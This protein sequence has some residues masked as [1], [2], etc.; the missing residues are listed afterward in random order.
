LFDYDAMAIL[1]H[2]DTEDRWLV[3]RREGSRPPA[4]L[5]TEELPA[6]V[7]KALRQ[8]TVVEEPNLL[9]GM[10]PGLAGSAGSGMYACLPARGA[11]IGLVVLEH[12]DPQHFSHRDAELLA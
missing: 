2:E 5:R 10:G 4:R 7:T 1:V 9:A 11:V 3:V 12:G 6:P 8:H